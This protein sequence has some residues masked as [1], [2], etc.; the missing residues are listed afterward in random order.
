MKNLIV[1]TQ[2][3]HRRMARLV[4]IVLSAALLS[5]APFHAAFA[6]QTAPALGSAGSFAVLS[7]APD[8]GGAVTLTNSTVIGDVGSSGL[9]ASVV[10]TGSTITGAVTAP[11]SAQVLTDFNNAYDQYADIPCTGYLD[12]AYTGATLTLTPGV[13]CNDAAVTF[14]DTTLTLDGQGNANAVWI[15]KIGTGGTGALTGTNF[16]VVMEGGGTSCNVYWWVAEAATLTTSNFLGTILAG[17]AITVT[18]GT[19]NGDALA[20]AGVTLTGANITACVQTSQ[21]PVP[22]KSKCNQGVGNGPEDCDPGNSNQENQ[23]YTGRSNDELGGT[24]GDPG[25]KGG[26]GK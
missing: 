17:A 2:T 10:N 9:K 7:A 24:P 26:N 3:H 13:Y 8:H 20:K 1:K 11:V 23:G 15:F 5:V 16:S 14:T 12:T 6:A 19:F 22:V 21:P 18:G 4:A 25:R